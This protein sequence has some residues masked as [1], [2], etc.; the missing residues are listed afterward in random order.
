MSCRLADEEPG[1]GPAAVGLPMPKDAAGRGQDHSPMT[2]GQ[3]IIPAKERPLV[4][5]KEVSP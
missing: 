4:Y 5:E 1:T 2:D 3:Q